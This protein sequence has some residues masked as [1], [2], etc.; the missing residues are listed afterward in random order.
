MASVMEDEE[1]NGAQMEFK[2]IIIII[3]IMHREESCRT[4]YHGRP[5]DGTKALFAPPLT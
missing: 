2:N 4:D 5:V 3:I 1:E